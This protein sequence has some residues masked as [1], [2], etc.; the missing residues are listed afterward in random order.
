MPRLPSPGR[1]LYCPSSD[2]LTA[3]HIVANALGGKLV[4]E[5][6]SCTECRKK[7]SKLEE[8][9]ARQMYW[10]LRLSLGVIGNRKHKDRPTHW[11]GVLQVNDRIE[12]MPIEVGKFPQ[13]YAVMEMPPPRILSGAVATPEM[14]QLRIIIKPSKA[15]LAKIAAQWGADQ[16]EFKSEIVWGTFARMIAKICHAYAVSVVG[17]DGVDFFLPPLIVSPSDY[18]AHYVGGVDDPEHQLAPP[19]DLALRVQDI[20]GRPYL[21]A[22]TTILGANRFP[23]YQC[24]V[25]EILNLDLIR[26]R[27]G[28]A[29]LVVASAVS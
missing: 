25:G 20:D 2:E 3:E 29:A 10:P 28:G 18:I 9:V 27:M 13:I 26:E 12:D 24:I 21:V 1:C 11:P 7:T 17:L 14:P 23:T 16:I 15:E 5:A 4:L 22:F 8:V 19:H 6:A